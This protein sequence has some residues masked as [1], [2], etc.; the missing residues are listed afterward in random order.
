MWNFIIYVEAL[1]LWGGDDSVTLEFKI[2]KK[3]LILGLAE[4]LMW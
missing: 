4:W 3:Y 2:L 1:A